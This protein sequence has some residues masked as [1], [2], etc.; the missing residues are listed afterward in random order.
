MFGYYLVFVFSR[1][2]MNQKEFA[3]RRRQLMRMMGKGSIAILPSANTRLRNR[4]V[5]YPFRQDSDFMYLTGFSEPDAI[6][7]LVPGRPEGEYV[8]FCREKDPLR[9]TWD[10]Y[11][12][13]PEG[14]VAEYEADDAFPIADTDDILPGL[15]ESC[16]GVYYTMGAH[17]EFDSRLIGWVTALRTYSGPGVQTPEEFVAIDHMLHDM[18]M[19]KSRAEISAMRKAAKV[20]TAGHARA[21]RAAAPGMFEYE[22]EAEIG[23]EFRRNGLQHSYNPIV[24][25][26]AN[27]CVL[28]Y[29]DNDRQMEDGD[30]VLIDAGCEVD[31]YAAD[32]TRTFPV[33][34]KFSPPQREI[35]D[36]VLRA[37]EA[38]IEHI[39]PGLSWHEFH[40]AAVLEI[41]RGLKDLGIL[42]GRLADLIRKEAYSPFFMHR[43][44][45]WL[46]MD[47]HDVG[48]YRVADQWRMLES[49]MMLTVEPG[50]YISEQHSRVKKCYRG[51]GIRIEDDVLVTRDGCEVLT[52]ALPVEAE[53]IEALMAEGK[54]LV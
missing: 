34:G 46:G 22:L 43:T 9:E 19:Y 11:R 27:G 20:A 30:L 51:I 14:A 38:A 28:H 42:K 31:C 49:G 44:G 47:V 12:A 17:P 33:N 16:E 54:Q 7:V 21:M 23:Y 53:A 39:A 45:H 18:R 15:I 35:Y 25:S 48:D 3:K 26:G 52:R 6:A 36:V 10:G 40:D 4:D 37:H 24:G 50:I 41:T 2:V 5:E 29:N 1:N 8:L 13:G 32:V